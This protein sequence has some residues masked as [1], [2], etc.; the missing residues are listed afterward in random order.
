MFYLLRALAVGWLVC[1]LAGAAH[2][3]TFSY[4]AAFSVQ[5]VK[6]EDGRLV[7]PLSSNKYTNVKISAKPL[8]QFVSDC[9]TDCTYHPA[10]QVTFVC[11]DWRRAFSN[12]NLFIAE[13]E[14][15]QELIL[16]FLLFQNPDKVVVQTPKEVSFID[17]DLQKRIENYLTE[18]VP[19]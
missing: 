6:Q 14:F 7:L 1:G 8:Y 18:L 15:N 12:E 13:V 4:G 10:K 17:K 16:T 11:T 9:Q 19:S 2:A 5:G 3:F